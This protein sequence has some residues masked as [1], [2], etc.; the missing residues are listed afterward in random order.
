MKQSENIRSKKAISNESF[1]RQSLNRK[2][3][4]L[5]TLIKTICS[6]FFLF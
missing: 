5:Q 1:S 3:L 2:R 6:S 4:H